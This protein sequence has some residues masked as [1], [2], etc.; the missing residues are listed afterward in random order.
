MSPCECC[1]Y[2][3]KV[4]IVEVDWREEPL[5]LCSVCQHS[6]LAELQYE[7]PASHKMLAQCIGFLANTMCDAH[8]LSYRERVEQ[9][10]NG[11]QP[12]SASY[13]SF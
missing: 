6:G 11:R 13:D 1:G 12:E 2:A 8:G 4:R 3:T 7:L 9:A 5:F 10:L